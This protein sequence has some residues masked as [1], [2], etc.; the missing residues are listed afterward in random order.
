MEGVREID[1]HDHFY[2]ISDHIACFPVAGEMCQHWHNTYCGHDI[3]IHNRIQ[4]VLVFQ[5][6]ARSCGNNISFPLWVVF[7]SCYWSV[8][9]R[10]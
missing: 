10:R 3:N 7:S 8:N 5:Q 4:L 1:N 9:A 6:E 2:T